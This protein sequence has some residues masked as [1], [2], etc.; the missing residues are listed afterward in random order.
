MMHISCIF[1]IFTVII[2]LIPIEHA[3]NRCLS[4]IALPLLATVKVSKSETTG[5]IKSWT[6]TPFTSG[7]CSPTTSCTSVV[8]MPMLPSPLR[9]RTVCLSKMLLLVNCFQLTYF[10][11]GGA[12][13]GHTQTKPRCDRIL[14]GK[15][16]FALKGWFNR[17]IQLFQISPTPCRRY[18]K[19]PQHPVEDI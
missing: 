17:V 10:V 6:G 5:L 19:Y 13:R 14:T 1:Q 11:R 8:L 2:I 4:H 7:V 3:S 9:Q 18:L 12:R 16:D 15:S